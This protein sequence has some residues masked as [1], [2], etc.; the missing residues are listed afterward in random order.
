MFTDKLLRLRLC[1]EGLVHGLPWEPREIDPLVLDG[2][3]AF[4]YFDYPRYHTM[5]FTNFLILLTYPLVISII[6]TSLIFE[7]A[8][9]HDV[10]CTGKTAFGLWKKYCTDKYEHRYNLTVDCLPS[11]SPANAQW[12]IDK[13]IE[14]YKKITL[15]L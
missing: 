10:Y 8:Q 4:F 9:I 14:E 13:L 7:S 5:L 15:F 1:L 2:E 3:N 12:K 6:C 11:T